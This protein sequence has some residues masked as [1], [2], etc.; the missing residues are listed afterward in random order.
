[1][2]ISR[3]FETV[4][5]LLNRRHVTAKELADRFE[6]SVRTIYRDIEALSQAGVPVYATQGAGGGIHISDAYVL[7]KSALTDNEQSQIILALQSLSVTGHADSD[8]LL[9]RL[10]SL[11]NKDSADWIEVDFSRWG[12]EA[13][14]RE[15]MALVKDAILHRQPITF[16]YHSGGGK[17][18]ERTACPVRLVYKAHS[19]Y[20]QAYCNEREDWRTFKLVRMSR[21][22][23]LPEP[24][25][26]NALGQPPGFG[27]M[28]AD[29]PPPMP[30]VCCT[31]RFGESIAWRVLDEFDPSSITWEEDGRLTVRTR[32]S[33]DDWFYSYVLSFGPAIEVVEPP[34]ARAFMKNML[35]GILG[36]YNRT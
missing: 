19:W 32:F 24:F 1:M 36:Q 5:I 2:Q 14:D 22:R 10:G 11:F 12:N 4:Y 13:H 18:T 34:E 8:H 29:E 26:R 3:L 17:R 21:V 9:S 35:E 31:L 27:D 16:T 6:V 28:Q 7:N 23:L 15:M 25:D 33:L 20:V 30:R